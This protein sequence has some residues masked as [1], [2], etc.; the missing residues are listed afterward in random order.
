MERTPC[1]CYQLDSDLVCSG[2]LAFVKSSRWGVGARGVDT[3]MVTPTE[4]FV[5]GIGMGNAKTAVPA[6]G[7][8][9]TKRSANIMLSTVNFVAD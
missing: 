3:A 6:A 1:W 2:G 9:G 4:L 5:G 7:A 8:Q